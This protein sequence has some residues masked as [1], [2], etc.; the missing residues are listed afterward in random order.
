M[1]L[2]RPRRQPLSLV[3]LVSFVQFALSCCHVGCGANSPWVLS[4][5]S[6]PPGEMVKEVGNPGASGLHFWGISEKEKARG[7]LYAGPDR[8]T[9]FS[10]PMNVVNTES[11][12]ASWVVGRPSFCYFQLCCPHPALALVGFSSGPMALSVRIP[13]SEQT[14]LPA[15]TTGIAVSF[16]CNHNPMNVRESHPLLIKTSKGPKPR[17][18]TLAV[19]KVQSCKLDEVRPRRK[20]AARGTERCLEMVPTTS[21]G[22]RNSHKHA[23]TWCEPGSWNIE[24]E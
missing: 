13:T 22:L 4:P 10:R 5:R 15:A 3:L 11:K 17:S 24:G 6:R 1:T 21:P 20:C 14:V 19:G 2:G 16:F 18:I 7:T 9:K 8:R 23:K 12:S